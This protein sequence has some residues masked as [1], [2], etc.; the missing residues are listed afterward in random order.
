MV[1][2][3]I[4][5][6]LAT[7]L[8]LAGNA[9]NVAITAD[10]ANNGLVPPAAAIA[11]LGPSGGTAIIVMLTMAILSTGSAECIAVSSLMSYDIYRTYFNP[12]ATGDQILKI[13]RMFVVGWAFVMAIASII[14]STF[15]IGLGFVYNFMATVLGSAVFP[16]ACS[17]YTDKLDATFA[18]AAAVLGC[19]CAVT[20]WLSYAGGLEGGVTKVNIADLYAQLYGGLTALLSSMVICMIGMVVKPM[21]FDWNVL[22]DEVKLVSG[23]G[24][25]NTKVH[26]FAVHPAPSA[27]HLHRMHMHM[28]KHQI[29][30]AR[31]KP[32]PLARWL[33]PKV[34]GD[35]NDGGSEEE[36]LAAKKWVFKYGWGYSIFLVVL[37]PL[38]CVPM[39]AFGKSTFQL[40]AGIALVWGWVGTIVI[41]GL[42]IYESLDGIKSMFGITK[43]A[44]IPVSVVKAGGNTTP[45]TEPSSVDSSVS[46]GDAWMGR[47]PL[48][49]A[50]APAA[51]TVTA[52]DGV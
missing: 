6:A 10:D 24:G 23:D 40:W 1:W 12:E 31:P 35:E 21:N 7:A 20:V 8:G 30:R 52:T 18:I 34:L 4:P 51:A 50:E 25:E 41:I 15:D 3:V 2:F 44:A 9:L 36:L 19:I 48:T 47:P 38:A 49:L 26:F 14:L 42:P 43:K 32:H 29:Y 22:L 39:G 16:I 13:S 27:V 46:A 28:H 37:W 45:P 11:L 17:I 33:H 5:F